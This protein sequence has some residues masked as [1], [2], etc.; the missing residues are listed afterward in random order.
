MQ[1]KLYGLL[2]DHRPPVAG[3]PH[4]PFTVDLVMPLTVAELLQYLGLPGDLVAGIAVNH[5]H[6]DLFTL[7]QPDDLVSL[8][9]PTSGG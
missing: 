5:N 7:L 4:Q 1:V 3:L 2:R 6:A 9:P 8:F